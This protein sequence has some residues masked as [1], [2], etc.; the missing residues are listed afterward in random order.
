MKRTLEAPDGSR[1]PS[2]SASRHLKPP[3]KSISKRSKQQGTIRRF[4]LPKDETPVIYTRSNSSVATVDPWSSGVRKLEKLAVSDTPRDLEQPS[5]NYVCNP[6]G[7]SQLVSQPSFNQVFNN[8]PQPSP[9]SDVHDDF[10]I[11][12][13][14][15]ERGSQAMGTP[16][17]LPT[18][19][20]ESASRSFRFV[21]QVSQ[22]DT[23]SFFAS[24]PPLQTSLPSLDVNNNRPMAPAA[25]AA[26]NATQG[27][28]AT[29]TQAIILTQEAT[30]VVPG[31]NHATTPDLG[32][33]FATME[34]A[35]LARPLFNIFLPKIEQRHLILIR[36]GESEYNRAMEQ[37]SSFKD[38]MIFDPPLTRKGREQA[39]GL[40]DKLK[41]ELSMFGD[42]LWVVSPLRRAIETFMLACPSLSDLHGAATGSNAAG[43]QATSQLSAQLSKLNV[44]VVPTISEFLITAGDVGSNPQQLAREFPCLSKQIEKLPEKWW[45]QEPKKP[46]C[47]EQK[48]INSREPKAHQLKRVSELTRWLQRRPEKF[49]IMVG[50][51]SFWKEFSKSS[52]PMKN[53]EMRTMSW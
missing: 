5:D 4:C 15:Y 17:M 32:S 23:V 6:P 8:L 14:D 49:I 51:C 13:Q 28:E 25:A 30:A 19:V 53:G 29:D 42:A 10:I 3:C 27:D 48:V 35:S 18:D 46:N 38:P 45:F 47:A 20:P 9:L 50:H 37:G 26:A 39:R 1:T 43:E 34:D 36:H 7:P 40:R 2:K 41:A 33:L 21:S 12:T 44:E 16:T 22:S 52:E 24:L 11:C 31:D